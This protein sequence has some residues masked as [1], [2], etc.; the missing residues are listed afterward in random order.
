MAV[1]RIVDLP[2][3]LEEIKVDSWEAYK[4]RKGKIISESV[5]LHTVLEVTSVTD[6]NTPILGNHPH[7]GAGYAMAKHEEASVTGHEGTTVKV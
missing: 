2:H 3:T 5:I 1:I 6:Y 7:N 4:H